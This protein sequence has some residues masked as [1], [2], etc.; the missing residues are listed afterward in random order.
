MKLLSYEVKSFKVGYIQLQKMS[1]FWIAFQSK[2]VSISPPRLG[3]HLRR[4]EWK[5]S[6]TYIKINESIIHSRILII[7]TPRAGF[8]EKR[9]T[10]PQLFGPET[11]SCGELQ[12]KNYQLCIFGFKNRLYWLRQIFS[13][14]SLFTPP[15]VVILVSPIP[16][17]CIL[18]SQCSPASTPFQGAV[19]S[20]QPSPIQYISFFSFCLTSFAL[21]TQIS[22]WCPGFGCGS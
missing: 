19:R 20:S 5:I 17:I 6:Q 1:K 16:I 7:L 21:W 13:E 10:V 9:R 8:Q 11:Y 4:S 2:K 15:I 3:N 22:R 12:R 14:H 18:Y